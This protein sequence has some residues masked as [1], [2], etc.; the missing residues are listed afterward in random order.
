M[1]R[2]QDLPFELRVGILSINA[3]KARALHEAR[4]AIRGW[5]EN[6]GKHAGSK[7]GAE[8]DQESYPYFPSHVSSPCIAVDKE[9]CIVWFNVREG[10]GDQP[11]WVTRYDKQQQGTT[12]F[13]D[14]GRDFDRARKVHHTE[15][16]LL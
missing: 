8:R 2:F 14:D 5:I 6:R 13:V 4:E 7:P 10:T 11:V 1:A 16:L 3:E 12:F 15:L 9:I